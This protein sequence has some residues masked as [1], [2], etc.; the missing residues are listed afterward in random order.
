MIRIAGVAAALGAGCALV[1]SAAEVRQSPAAQSRAALILGQVVDGS[2]DRP[3]AGVV[4]TLSAPPATPAPAPTGLQPSTPPPRRAITDSSG[5]FVFSELPAGK[6]AFSIGTASGVLIGGY[7]MRRP[8]GATQPFELAEGQRA[9]Q[10]TLR[11]WRH[12]AVAGTVV[13]QDGEPIVE[14]RVTLLRVEIVAGHRRFRVGPTTMTDDRGMY[15]ISRVEPGEYTVYLPYAQV[16]VPVGVQAAYDSASSK[17]QAVRQE[18][19]R[20]YGLDSSGVNGTGLRIGDHLLIRASNSYGGNGQTGPSFMSPPPDASGRLS[21]YPM[22]FY[23]GVTA[24]SEAATFAVESGQDRAGTDLQ[25][26]LVPSVQVSGRIAGIDGPARMITVRLVAQSAADADNEDGIE[27][28]RTVTDAAGEFTFL[29]VPSGSYV[30]KV[31]RV[32]ITTRPTTMTS[33]SVGGT[34]MYSV[35]DDSSLP[36][37]PLPEAPTESQSLPLAVGDQ[38]IRNLTVQLQAG[39]RLSGRLVYHGNAPQLTA[40]QLVRVTITLD[41]IDG[42]VFPGAIG[43]GQFEANGQFRTLGLLPG[44]Y[45]LRLGGDLGAWSLDS[46]SVG[47]EMSP[48]DQPIAIADTDVSGVVVTLTDRPGSISGSVRDPRGGVDGTATVLIFPASRALWVDTS[49]SPRR[50]RST[51]VSTR[52]IY[53]IDNLPAGDYVVVAIDDRFAADW[54]RSQRLDSLSR[55]GTRVTFG[56]AERKTLD[57]TTQVIR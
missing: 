1:L 46:V 16:S 36:P 52:G 4:V 55:S 12:G 13:D 9:G 22:T 7:G 8:G 40:D 50:L 11:A 26:R 35:V 25:T 47:G 43:K 24:L 39:P 56:A 2:S 30:L 57:L 6:Y 23:P 34:T 15:R 41:P 17:G 3:M 28:A 19:E 21:V 29:G 32:P 18:F 44:R 33:V 31:A 54:Q 38:D 14:T 37:L 49:A 20:T 51:R 10:V 5:R 45:M 42:R 27:T 53:R 48:P